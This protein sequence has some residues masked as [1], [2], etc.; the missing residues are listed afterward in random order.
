MFFKQC[1]ANTKHSM[2]VSYDYCQFMNTIRKSSSFLNDS[3]RQEG[4]SACL[5]QLL[6]PEPLELQDRAPQLARIGHSP[7]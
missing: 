5:G 6:L 4:N 3:S 2:K 1:L 7:Y